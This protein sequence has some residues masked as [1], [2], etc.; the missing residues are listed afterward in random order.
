MKNHILVGLFGLMLSFNFSQAQ[1]D[2][3][4]DNAELFYFNGTENVNL[5]AYT[6]SAAIYFNTPPTINDLNALIADFP[7]YQLLAAKNLLIL[8]DENGFN[9]L[10]SFSGRR[11]FLNRYNLFAADAY[12]AL[13]MF[14]LD[15]GYPAWFTD[16]LVVRLKSNIGLT[17]L[18]PYLADYGATFIRTIRNTTH[19]IELKAIEQ[20]LALI[21]ELYADGLIVWGQPDFRAP[22]ER[23]NDPLYPQQFQMNNTGQTID[24]TAGQADID[25]DAPEAWSITTGSSAITVAVMDDGLEAHP[26]LP[27]IIGG[28][29]PLNNGNGGVFSGSNHGEACA[30]IVAAK[31]N[32]IGVRGV[33][34]D[35]QLQ[36]INIFLGSESPSDI[37]D[38]FYWAIDNDADVISNSWGYT[39]FLIFAECNGN[40]HPV[41]TDAIND[42]ATNGRNGKGCVI[43]FASGNNG[44]N[45]ATYP[46][47]ID[48]V[49]AVGAITSSGNR[50]SYSNYGPRLDIVAPSDGGAGDPTIRTTDRPGSAGYTTGNYTNT[51]GGTSAACPV[52][53][54]VGA[55]VLSIDPS[56]TGPEVHAILENTADDMGA[57]G[58]D[59]FYGHGRVNAHQAVLEAQAGLGGCTDSD[60]DSVCDDVD[61][62]IGVNDL[63]LTLIDDPITNE[64]NTTIS[65]INSNVFI[66]NGLNV[67][68]EAGTVI[69]LTTGFHAESGATFSALIKACPIISNDA[70]VENRGDMILSK[71]LALRAYPNPFQENLTIDYELI[72]AANTQIFITDLQGK[73]V[74]ELQANTWQ[75]NGKHHITWHAPNH[76]SGLYFLYLRT[77]D[78]VEVKKLM[79]NR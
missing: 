74:A 63:P 64:T 22:I 24:G 28:F 69:T 68:Y 38:G 61:L 47:N 49:L 29:S 71:I 10:T 40:L 58:F 65:S 14:V 52:V 5:Q 37:A 23:S 7:N 20:Q 18:D 50:S 78:Q 45:C 36:S 62:C 4:L 76:F 25:V 16:K 11:N 56:L 8:E 57:N 31:H 21:Q 17:A 46:S 67:N 79:I 41:L 73:Q 32:N 55:L 77:G 66:T 1:S 75:E 19:Q 59:N 70:V 27:S 51:F 26:D 15:G 35:V 53:A 30:G 13:P 2:W 60:N 42:A 44:E 6:N 34:P 9:N 3:T 33:A 48:A 39:R 43:T 72:E 54:G 12:E